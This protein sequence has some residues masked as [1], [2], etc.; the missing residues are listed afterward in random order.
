M[1]WEPATTTRTL[2]RGRQK[3]VSEPE[4]DDIDRHIIRSWQA[5]QRR[6]CLH[7]GRPLAVHDTDSIEDYHVGY[8]TCTAT[9]A[10][11]AEQAAQHKRDEADDV[12]KAAGLNPDRPRLWVAWTD[13][14]GEPTP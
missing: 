3:A 1:G 12:A 4:W 5:L 9:A 2:A 13:E 10:I 11:D 6:P 14:E 7:C 8:F